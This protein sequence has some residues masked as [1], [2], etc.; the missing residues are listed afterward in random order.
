MILR[1]ISL[2]KFNTFGLDYEADKLISIRNEEEA[3]LHLRE[4]RLLR[5]P[6]LII[7]SGSNLL[8]TGDYE[9]TV[10]HMEIGEIRIEETHPQYVIAS[11]GAGVI[12]DDF[13]K[14]SV[15]RGFGGLE[16]LSMIPGTVGASPIQNIGAYGAEVKDSVEKVMVISRDDGSPGEL[17]NNECGFSYRNSIFKVESKGK[18]LITRVWFRLSKTP[19][20]KLDY[21]SLREDVKR[22]GH[23][24]LK[25]VREAVINTR[26][27]KLPDPAKTGNAG[28][29]FKNPVISV[30]Q[31]EDL[32]RI[33]P[34]MPVF[35]DLSGGKKLAAAW[36]IE[37]C[38]WKGKR[39]GDAGVHPEQALVLINNGKATGMDIYRLSEAIKKTVLEK[40][41]V[42]LEREVEIVGPI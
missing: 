33:F 14:W 32:L 9:G 29:F 31:S 28:S 12:W 22:F 13:V 36:L 17:S 35:D 2:K 21:G 25:N 26:T 8:F 10:L 42:E 30:G 34:G 5:R 20:L 23:E 3:L 15:D 4:E 6:V 40:F 27:R 18:Y 41:G 24:N 11:S 38:G 19:V 16:N 1:N 39:I 7:G 37:Q